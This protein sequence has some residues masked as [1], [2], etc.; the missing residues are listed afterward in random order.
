MDD[1]KLH[2]NNYFNIILPI[3]MVLLL[4][5]CGGGSSLPPK[6]NVLE[7][8]R[9]LCSD[10]L[11]NDANNQTDCADSNCSNTSYCS[12]NGIAGKKD[13]QDKWLD[14]W[15]LLPRKA[16][17]LADAE[18]ICAGIGARL[19]TATELF[20]NRYVDNTSLLTV[21]DAYKGNGEEWLW[22][23]IKRTDQSQ[24]FI[25][26]LSEG[27]IPP[28]GTPR[29]GNVTASANTEL[30]QF[31][32]IW[33]INA[34]VTTGFTKERCFSKPG[35]NC[36]K[37]SENVNMDSKQR[38]PLDYAGAAQECRM[39][40]AS[41]PVVADYATA[42]QAGL[43]HGTNLWNYTANAIS[44]FSTNPANL[45]NNYGVSIVRFND[46]K[47][48]YWSYI[49]GD[50][51]AIAHP[52]TVHMNYRFRCIGLED[53][54]RITLPV[55]PT[56]QGSQCFQLNDARS[57]L[58]AD[59]SD[60]TAT[61]FAV[62]LDTCR[63]LGADI[64][65]QAEFSDL[66]RAGWDNGSNTWLWMA[67]PVVYSDVNKTDPA[68]LILTKHH[69]RN[70]VGKWSGKG[71]SNWTYRNGLGAPREANI[72][73]AYRCVWRGR[74]GKLPTACTTGQVIK[75]QGDSFVCVNSVTGDSNGNANP[76]GDHQI[77]A[78]GNAW[79]K[80]TRPAEKYST[81]NQNCQQLGAR[82][83]T[84]NELYAA[85]GATK[86]LPPIVDVGSANLNL[87]TLNPATTIGHHTLVSII[88]ADVSSDVE[89]NPHEYR[90]IWPSLKGNVLSGRACYGNP[91]KPCFQDYVDSTGT[92]VNEEMIAD[93]EDR[94]ALTMT[95]A[96]TEC[97]QAGGKLPDLREFAKLT[98]NEWKN[99]SNKWLWIND[100][101]YWYNGGYGYALGRW[102]GSATKSWQYQNPAMGAVG[103]A[104]K[105][106]N[107][108]CIYSTVV[109]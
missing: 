50:R 102:S 13:V 85:R 88:S 41:L 99:G 9:A 96:I 58:I 62:A 107:F 32:C 23:S 56:C 79:D 6:P 28:S 97:Q 27:A 106:R 71:L 66:V 82:L 22:T 40:G 94:L 1:I 10:G 47:A 103:V 35:E 49:S 60:R 109:R 63:E 90:C 34:K 18:K 68:N 12:A 72:A 16:V 3:V 8:T 43:P 51:G 17:T 81:A 84:A 83:P 74:L 76:N 89:T 59:N 75:R 45:S 19:P 42:I 14:H 26:R 36:F 48:P 93:S 80:F 78:W 15:D 39:S 4:S 44:W 29:T 64:P 100:S 77:D 95:A 101:M 20:R 21:D 86:Y 11:D 65:N 2:L 54:S 7:V 24:Q 108:R 104:T 30:R 91:A 53:A 38:A 33:P 52:S 5:S 69:Y 87:W 55:E 57:M 25:I 73:S 67:D 61:T 70:A 46:L 37:V 31:R 105:P 98:H 92:K